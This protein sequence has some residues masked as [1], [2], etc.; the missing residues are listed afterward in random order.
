MWLSRTSSFT[1]TA[2]AASVQARVYRRPATSR[3]C[4]FGQFGQD[5]YGNDG[6]LEAMLLFLREARP[7]AILSCVCT[8][9][10]KVERD[11]G[12]PSVPIKWDG[13]SSPALRLLNKL[14]LTIP[15]KLGNWLAAIRHMRNF[16]V[17]LLPGTGPLCDFYAG[18]FG[19]PYAVFRWTVAA[20]L[21]GA[22]VF[23]VSVGAGPAYR[24][25]SRWLLIY[26]TRLATYRSFR[27]TSS[28][29]YLG[30]AGVDTRQDEVYP[31]LAFKLP[32]PDLPRSGSLDSNPVT[33]VVG[34]MNY[35]GWQGH[36]RPDDT[37]YDTYVAKITRVVRNLLDRGFRIRILVGDLSDQHAVARLQSALAADRC[38]D[39]A[40]QVSCKAPDRI[41]A[42]PVNC[43]ADIMRQI[44]DASVVI[45]S[46]FHNVVCALKLARP[47]ISLG[48]ENK[49]DAVMQTF[50]LAQFCQHIEHFD[51]DWVLHQVEEQLSNHAFY[52]QKIQQK[53]PQLRTRIAE[54]ERVLV[55]LL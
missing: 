14:T 36:A 12:I 32:V 37:I 49:N 23:F 9:P 28:K 35:N 47:T 16:D 41:I 22:S 18:P 8:D 48:Y 55:Q 51:P 7:E 20:R 6:S 2:P 54:Q 17:L 40:Q 38:T 44:S 4:L 43:L 27:D 50:G 52:E 53:L 10:E 25:L 33:I 5:N 24:P 21:A 31:D 3:I 30:S 42:E 29:E 34:V 39:P 19:R 13:I 15:H 45:A 11:H 1:G 46:R 26:A